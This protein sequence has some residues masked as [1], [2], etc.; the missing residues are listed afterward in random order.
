MSVA[1]FRSETGLSETGPSETVLARATLTKA[2]APV[3]VDGAISV[4]FKAEQDTTRIATLAEHGGYRLKFP[5]PVGGALEGVIVNTGGGVAGGDRVTFSVSAGAGARAAI[6]TATAERIYR[7]TGAAAEFDVRLAAACDATLAWL[8]QA[9]ILFSQARLKRRFA[10]DLASG[11]RLLMAETTIFGREAS[12]EIMGDG[13][14]QDVWRVR[15]GGDLM[16][17][18][19]TRLD[20]DMTELLARP[21][22]A[23]SVRGVALLLCVAPEIEETTDAVRAAIAGCDVLAGV[24]AW[25]GMLVMRAQASRLDALQLSLRRAI[26]ALQIVKPPQAWSA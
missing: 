12:G 17:A 8:P 6:T 7:S 24:S 1:D 10:V 23:G 14:L 16:V 26:E 21:A 5:D 15:R 19:A 3:R 20:G 25:N 22:I 11:A 18:E 13:L 4:A 9:T 2:L